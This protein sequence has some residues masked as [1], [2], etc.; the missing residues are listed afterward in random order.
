LIRQLWPGSLL[1][2]TTQ[3]RLRLGQAFQVLVNEGTSFGMVDM[4]GIVIIP[5]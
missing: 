5:C 3:A 2:L 1:G 4:Q